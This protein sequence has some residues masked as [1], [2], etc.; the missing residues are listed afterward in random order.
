MFPAPSLSSR[1]LRGMFPAPSLSSRKLRGMLVALFRGG[2]GG[3]GR[4]PGAVEAEKD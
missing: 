1:K 3:G 4:F 2:G